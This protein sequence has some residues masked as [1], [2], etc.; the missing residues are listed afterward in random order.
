MQVRVIPLIEIEDSYVS[1]FV[2]GASGVIYRRT[3]QHPEARRCSQ[4]FPHPDLETEEV[5][6][7]WLADWPKARFDIFALSRR[8]ACLAVDFLLQE[9][10]GDAWVSRPWARVYEATGDAAADAA[11]PADAGDSAESASP[12][13]RARAAGAASV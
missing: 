13:R 3:K 7:K 8:C 9:R 2:E 6:E 12:R 10:Q 4:I 11:T 1:E 5:I